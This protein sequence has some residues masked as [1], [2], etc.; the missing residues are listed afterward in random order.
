MVKTYSTPVASSEKKRLIPC[1]ICGERRFIP[2]L[3]C[4]GFSYARC[5]SCGLV[6]INP[7]P[8]EE[9]IKKRYSARYGEDYLA[10]ELANEESFLKL[11]VLALKDA[12]FA[13]LEDKVLPKGN[14]PESNGKPRLLDIGCATGSLI[15]A[16][17]ERGWECTGVEISRPQAEYGRETRNLD[18]RSL[19]LEE[20]R[21][22]SDT[23][24]AVLASHLM[25]HLNN[26]AALLKE[27]HRILRPG[28]RFFVT[29]PNIAGFQA[30]L[31]RGR[32][33]SAIFDH[34]YLFSIKTLSRL[35]REQGFTIERTATWGGLAAGTAPLPVKRL[36]DKAAKRFGFGDVMIIR[37]GKRILPISLTE[38]AEGHKEHKGEKA[39]NPG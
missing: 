28:G 18:V 20:N 24:D 30:R 4:E 25:E 1:V 11:Q 33:R 21:F 35:L 29:T 12:G 36:F 3:S 32:W 6:Q 26:P 15:A 8:E 34:L 9:E 27:I 39:K 37:A 14:E 16:L 7:Q 2:A 5:V 31:F 19:P 10:Y 23:F 13:D 22:P 38:R 17:R